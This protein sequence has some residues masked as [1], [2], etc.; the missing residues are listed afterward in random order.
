M[1]PSGNKRPAAPV[2]SMKTRAQTRRE[3]GNQASLNPTEKRPHDSDE[4]SEEEIHSNRPGKRPKLQKPKKTS[5]KRPSTSVPDAT[6]STGAQEQ[7]ENAT[8]EDEEVSIEAISPE[9][10]HEQSDPGTGEDGI[11]DNDDDVE[12]IVRSPPRI[13]EDEIYWPAIRE[14]YVAASNGS[15][16]EFRLP[17]I[18][19][20]GHTMVKYPGCPEYEYNSQ[21]GH[22]GEHL[23][24]LPSMAVQDLVQPVGAG[25]NVSSARHLSNHGSSTTIISASRRQ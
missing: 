2:H 19:C 1:A 15:N 4:E 6:S 9:D 13:V 14:A 10:D 12:E 22:Y 7:Q 3:Q 11:N 5:S 25:S 21:T 18:V 24:I 16:I 23:V 8:G 17:C 20:R